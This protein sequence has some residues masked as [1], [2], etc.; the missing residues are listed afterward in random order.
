VVFEIDLLH[1]E[2][3]AS[4]L[5]KVLPRASQYDPPVPDLLEGLPLLLR[6]RAK[7]GSLIDGYA[8]WSVIPGY[9]YTCC[10]ADV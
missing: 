9:D 8:T 3:L 6:Q 5:S 4:V 10:R 1:L 7:V 2:G